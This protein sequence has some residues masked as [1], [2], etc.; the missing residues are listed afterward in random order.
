M[1]AREGI[2]SKGVMRVCVNSHRHRVP[3]QD[4]WGVDGGA[5]L[6]TPH[7]IELTCTSV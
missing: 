4:F 3:L 6:D 7:A 5:L 1:G 2:L